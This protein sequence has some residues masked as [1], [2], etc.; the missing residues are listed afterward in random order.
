M[1]QLEEYAVVIDYMPLGK[2]TDAGRGPMCQLLG[3]SYFTILEATVK[4]EAKMSIGEKV[5]VGKDA[6]EKIDHIKGRITYDQLTTGARNELKNAIRATIMVREAEFVNFFN[7]SGALTMRV[8]SLALLPGIGK[9]H[10][11]DIMAEREKKPFESMADIAKRVA[12][13]PD[14]A[15]L[16][17]QRIEK[18]L[19]GN[20]KHYLFA[21]P[22]PNPDEQRRFY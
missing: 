11:T 22:P 2:A 4:P 1:M 9:K 10:M 5:Y 13:L 12:L 20:E 3:T 8:N 6:R 18:E 7:K 16:I 15:H 17:I 21:R 19:E 14:P